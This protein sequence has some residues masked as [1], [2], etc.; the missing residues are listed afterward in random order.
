MFIAVLF[1]VGKTLKT[2][3]NPTIR[4]MT[5]YVM[6]YKGCEELFSLKNMLDYT[7]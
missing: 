4:G 1:M 5:E 6:M 2:K 7:H 3:R